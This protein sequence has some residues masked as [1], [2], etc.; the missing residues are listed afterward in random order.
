MTADA[1]LLRS[2]V[3]S[4]LAG[5]LGTYTFTNGQSVVALAVIANN[6]EIYPPEGTKVSGLEIVIYHPYL[7]PKPLLQ[8]HKVKETWVIHLKQ[9]QQGKGVQEA[10]R[11]FLSSNLSDFITEEIAEVPADVRMGIPAGA[12]IKL[13]KFVILGA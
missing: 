11:A 2:I 4:A 9:W 3:T 8:G 13:F 1:L 6:G 5:F 7:S 10:L 12:Q